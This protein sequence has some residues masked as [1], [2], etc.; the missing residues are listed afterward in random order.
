MYIIICP[1]KGILC[2]IKNSSRI[3]VTDPE[4]LRPQSVNRKKAKYQ[5]VCTGVDLVCK[6]ENLCALTPK[7]GKV[8]ARRLAVTVPTSRFSPLWLQTYDEVL[9][10]VS[11]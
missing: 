9:F 7:W 5:T 10:P 1:H 3:P 2:V 4:G 11:G 8:H 6:E